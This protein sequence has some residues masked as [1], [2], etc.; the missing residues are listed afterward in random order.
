M[1]STIIDGI[2]IPPVFIVQKD[3]L[4]LTTNISTTAI[5]LTLNDVVKI[6]PLVLSS[7]LTVFGEFM[8]VVVKPELH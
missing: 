8:L 4:A 2:D 3:L 6:Q 5:C 7:N 1:G